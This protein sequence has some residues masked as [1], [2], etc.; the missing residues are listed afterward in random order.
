MRSPGRRLADSGVGS[1][2]E[3]IRDAERNPVAAGGRRP[4][5][6]RTGSSPRGTPGCR[7][8]S[9]SARRAG[10]PVNCVSGFT[11]SNVMN[12]RPVDAVIV[13]RSLAARIGSSIRTQRARSPLR[14]VDEV[15]VALEAGE[16]HARRATGG[17]P[18]AD[19]PSPNGNT[20]FHTPGVTGAVVPDGAVVLQPADACRCSG[21]RGSSDDVVELQR[22]QSAVEEVK[23]RRH[24]AEHAS[25]TAARCRTAPAAAAM[26]ANV[27]SLRTTPPSDPTN[28][29]SGLRGWN[30][31]ARTS[32]WRGSAAF[33]ASLAERARSSRRR[34]SN[35]SWSRRTSASRRRR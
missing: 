24:R 22:L 27:P 19:V 3:R 34:R 4:I 16:E 33:C 29:M 12:C 15:A 9:S 13:A 8:C 32:T 26:F 28:A 23:P 21:A 18:E 5:R 11:S 6:R 25:R 7:R 20:L 2:R 14:E 1:G 30:T 10:T 31:I 35:G 17:I